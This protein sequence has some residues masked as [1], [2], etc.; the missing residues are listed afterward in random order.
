MECGDSI[1]GVQTNTVWIVRPGVKF[2][3]MLA[4]HRP[5]LKI[6]SVV[7]LVR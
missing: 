1:T 4:L 7:K 2:M 6:P 3:V 5:T